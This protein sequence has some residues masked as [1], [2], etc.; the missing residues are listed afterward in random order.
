MPWW[1][2]LRRWR[3]RTDVPLTLAL[4]QAI[5]LLTL[6]LLFLLFSLASHEAAEVLENALEGDLRRVGSRIAQGDVPVRID[7]S[8]GTAVRLLDGGNAQLLVGEWP[9]GGKLFGDDTAS[10]RLALA[11]PD[12]SLCDDQT[13]PDGGRLEGCVRLTGFVEERREQLAQLGVAFATG[14][15]GVLVV[16]VYATRKALSPLRVATLAIERVD[17]R[18]LESRIPTRG[19]GDDV[20]RHAE[21][22]NRVLARLESA[23]VRIFAFN[24]DVAHELRTPV[25]R[26]LNLTEVALLRSDPDAAHASLDAIRDAAEEM[27]RL[28]E[29][30]LLLARGDEGRLAVKLDPVD[31]ATVLDGLLELYRPSCEEKGV[32]LERIGA[33]GDAPVLSDRPLLERAVSNLIDN[34][35]RHTPRGGRIQ[36]EVSRR[37]EVTA[38]VVSDSG[39]GVP[40]PQRERIFDRFVQLDAARRGGAGLGLPIARMIARALGG[41]VSVTESVL[42]GARFELQLRA[43]PS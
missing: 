6:A 42:G 2:E 5:T 38:I 18:H 10:L 24:A 13:L 11:S 26:I 7:A 35:L 28:I 25:N 16:S 27:R 15:L 30:M 41:D 20:D 8:P 34:A 21:A 9:R 33:P 29:D 4:A 1:R 37:G 22:L 40:A 43:R 31:S 36:I 39:E 32:S 14:L 17:E 3:H 12:G 19:T 23:F